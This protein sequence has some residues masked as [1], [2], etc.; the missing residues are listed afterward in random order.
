M[1]KG[2]WLLP[3]SIVLAAV[4]VGGSLVYYSANAPRKQAGGGIQ[5]ASSNP[6]ASSVSDQEIQKQVLPTEGI[7]LPIVWG[8]MGKKLTESGVIDEEKFRSVYEQRG[9]IGPEGEELLSGDSNE[10][11]RVT[12]QNAH[13]LLN[14]AWALGL[15]NKN[16][17]LE[18]GPMVD[19]RFGSPANFA[20][21]GG[22]TLAQGSAMDHYSK[23]SFIQLTDEQQALVER[24]SQNIYR[25]CC[26]NSTYFPDCN[27]GMAMLGLLE[28]MAS[29]GVGEQEMYQA[30]LAL[31]SYWFPSTYLTVAKW[32]AQKGIAWKDVNPQEALS[33]QVSS[34]QGY[35]RIASEVNPVQAG[36]ASCGV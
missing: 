33:A 10:R 36:G 22:W 13:I 30:A 17:I 34:V 5:Q 24:V 9:G 11:I 16:P 6:A 4:I 1:Q 20:S 19:K 12:S 7:E 2:G 3:A 26:G 21:T 27:H 29:Q 32:Y 23:H 18:E 31:N 25:P 35:R 14:L 28:L 15:G 8:D